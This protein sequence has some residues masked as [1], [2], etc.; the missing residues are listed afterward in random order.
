MF[1][2]PSSRQLFVYPRSRYRALPVSNPG[3]CL[4]DS[5]RDLFTGLFRRRHCR[6]LQVNE[7]LPIRHPLIEQ[8]GS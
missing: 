4:L 7:I 5:R 6:H 3:R 2:K 1:Q 8:P